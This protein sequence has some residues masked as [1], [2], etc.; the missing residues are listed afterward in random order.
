MET[1]IT[2]VREINN[3]AIGYKFIPRDDF[4]YSPLKALQSGTLNYQNLAFLN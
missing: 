1:A 3:V 4:T 2:A